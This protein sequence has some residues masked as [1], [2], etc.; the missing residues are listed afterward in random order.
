MLP[1]VPICLA[2]WLQ[3]AREHGCV[4]LINMELYDGSKY[5]IP[6][7]KITVQFKEQKLNHNLQIMLISFDVLSE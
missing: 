1:E 7:F 2:Y 3:K 5:F 6:R 4:S